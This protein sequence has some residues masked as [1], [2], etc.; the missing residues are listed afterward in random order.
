MTAGRLSE[1]QARL[2]AAT[3]GPWWTGMHD[4]F[5][6]T[7]EGPEA[8]SHPVAQRLINDDATFI[9]HAPADIAFLLSEVSRLST[10]IEARGQLLAALIDPDPC[11]WD[12][13]HSCQ[14]H[15]FFYIP[16]GEKCPNEEAREIVALSVPVS[17]K[18]KKDV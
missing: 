7:V 18:E 16:Q 5:S 15:G 10:V 13:N 12:H 8:D 14:A 6:Y 17:P 11:D 9:A 1:I 3:E 2:N 4:G